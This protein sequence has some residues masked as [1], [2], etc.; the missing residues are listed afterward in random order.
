MMA[1]PIM[2][3]LRGEGGLQLWMRR[4]GTARLVGEL[5]LKAVV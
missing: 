2:V 4:D 3:Q 1:S 5:I